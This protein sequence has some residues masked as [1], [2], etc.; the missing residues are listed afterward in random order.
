MAGEV[1]AGGGFTAGGIET[2][3]GCEGSTGWTADGPAGGRGPG[4]AAGGGLLMPAAGLDSSPLRGVC[5]S[6]GEASSSKPTKAK[7][8]R[9]M[10]APR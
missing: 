3:P 7:I 6:A 4:L 2:M 10:Q 1:V 5:A 8:C 9:R